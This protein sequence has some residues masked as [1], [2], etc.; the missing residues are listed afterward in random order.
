MSQKLAITK[1]NLDLISKSTEW[2]YT[3]WMIN[4]LIKTSF[5]TLEKVEEAIIAFQL[6]TKYNLDPAM[7]EMYAFK[8]NSGNMV[9]IASTAWFMKIARQQP[10]FLS[11]ESHAVYEWEDF[12]IDTGTWEV[13]HKINPAHRGKGKNPLWAYSRLKRNWQSDLIKWVDWSDYAKQTTKFSSPWNDYKAA[14]IWKC[15]TTVLLREA[16][17]LS[18][19]YWEEETE[20]MRTQWNYSS[21]NEVSQEAIEKA[22]EEREKTSEPQ[23]KEAEVE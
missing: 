21:S 10:W 12:S 17:G 13:S 1:D 7:K 22:I 15:A 16:Y 11:I 4:T 19:L 20:K 2:K 14:M 3:Q 23:V 5:P 8:D 6:A 9:C 18:W